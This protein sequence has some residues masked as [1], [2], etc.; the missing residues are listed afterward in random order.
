VVVVL[1]NS[2]IIYT[3]PANQQQRQYEKQPIA[4]IGHVV[5]NCS[6]DI[7]LRFITHIDKAAATAVD[8][9][10]NFV[11]SEAILFIDKARE[12]K[13]TSSS[14][15]SSIIVSTR[16]RRHQTLWQARDF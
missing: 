8:L 16:T 5:D 10:T 3:I 6:F 4:R 7:Y 11:K 15:S 12:Q 9:M 13:N 1:K 2:A 14:S